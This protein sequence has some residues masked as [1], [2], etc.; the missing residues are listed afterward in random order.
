MQ[1]N[2]SC[3]FHEVGVT[4]CGGA[5]ALTFPEDFRYWTCSFSVR[6]VWTARGEH[7]SSP[8]LLVEDDPWEMSQFLSF[9]L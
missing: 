8:G 1:E 2:D 5:H 4:K 6:T 3:F 9:F 7:H